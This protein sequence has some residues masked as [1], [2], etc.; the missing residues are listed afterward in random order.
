MWTYCSNNQVRCRTCLT[1]DDRRGGSRCGE[2]EGS[3]G[4]EMHGAD[5]WD[6]Q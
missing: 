3:E 1:L 5:R 2:N 4:G 6:N